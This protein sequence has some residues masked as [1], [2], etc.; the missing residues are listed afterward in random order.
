MVEKG[1]VHDMKKVFPRLN[2]PYVETYKFLQEELYQYEFTGKGKVRALRSPRGS[3]ALI[4][5]IA[6][7]MAGIVTNLE[8]QMIGNKPLG[9]EEVIEDNGNSNSDN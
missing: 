9:T 5:E 8:V 1:I 2:Q 4:E 7:Q 3:S 6:E